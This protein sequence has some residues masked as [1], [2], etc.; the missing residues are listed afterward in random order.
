MDGLR[1]CADVSAAAWIAPRLGGAFGAVTRTVP[2]GFDAYVRI[3][4]PVPDADGGD[5][6]WFHVAEVTGRQPHALMQWHALVGSSDPFNFEGSLWPHGSPD[7]GNLAPEVLGP[8]CELLAGHTTT[9][10][11]CF[12]CLWEGWGWV[13]R[14]PYTL[15]SGQLVPAAFSAEELSRP[16]VQ[17]PGRKYLLLEGPLEAALQIG[18]RHPGPFID[19]QSPNICWPQDHAWCLASEIDF[20]STLVGGSTELVNSILNDP[21]FEAWPVQPDDSI[22][23]DGDRINQ[24]P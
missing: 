8:L 9:P 12:F 20:D 2:K 3:L 6:T 22:A 11:H 4:H 19:P 14:G 16:R 1:V 17:H 21:T 5:T 15:P 7:D 23:A 18:D 13:E 24:V 10:E